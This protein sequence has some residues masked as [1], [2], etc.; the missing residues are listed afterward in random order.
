MIR[1]ISILF[2]C[3][4]LLVCCNESEIKENEFTY[5]PSIPYPI[6]NSGDFW[7]DKFNQKGLQNAL[8]YQDRIY[9]NTID[10][11]SN[12]NYLYCLDLTNGLVIWRAKVETWATQPVF[13]FNNTIIY[14]SYLGNIFAFDENGKELWRNKYDR[15][16]GGHLGDTINSTFLIRTPYGSE[17]SIYDI[18]SGKLIS[19]IE[20]DSIKKEI[21]KKRNNINILQKEFQFERQGIGYKIKTMENLNGQYKIE[22]KTVASNL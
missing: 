11:G 4:I 7:P 1:I 6:F 8:I 18:E 13:C 10:V 20:N 17:I 15:P 12:N 19:K 2:S 3:F 16:Y 14:C 22:I 5:N 21:E 9:C